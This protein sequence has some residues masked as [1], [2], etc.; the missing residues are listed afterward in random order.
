LASSPR[1][2]RSRIRRSKR[3]AALFQPK[4]DFSSGHDSDSRLSAQFVERISG[5]YLG[6][7]LRP[8]SDRPAADRRTLSAEENFNGSAAEAA[9]WRFEIAHI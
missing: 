2:P 3:T 1:Q 5:R 4:L 6:E 8:L 9:T 7:P